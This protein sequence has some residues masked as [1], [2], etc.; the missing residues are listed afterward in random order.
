MAESPDRE[1][2]IVIGA[3]M[4]G[5][6]AAQVLTRHFRKVTLV[7]RDRLPDLPGYRKGVPQSRHTHLL[8]GLG[9]RSLERQ[10]PGLTAQLLA[11]G[12]VPL[13]LPGDAC[14]LTPAGWCE[15]FGTGM[16]FV[17]ASRDLIEWTV[18]QRVLSEPRLSLMT[19]TEATALVP[20]PD[21]SGIRGV[22]LRS[23]ASGEVFPLE[24]DLVL[25]ASGRGSRAPQWLTELGWPA[26]QE[27]SAPTA[28]GYASRF[29]ANPHR[30][31][32]DWKFLLL[33]TQ[34]PEHTRS[35]M[36]LPVDGDRWMVSLVGV[37]D[38]HPPTSDAGFLEFART[39]RSP[40]LYEAIR[41]AVP[42]TPVHSFRVPDSRRRRFDKMR[43]WPSGFALVGD[44][45]CSLNP[46]Y[47][48]GM[49]IAAATALA[50]DEELRRRSRKPLGRRIQR[51]AANV[52]ADAWLVA[53]S[54]DLRYLRPGQQVRQPIY[55]T[56][57]QGYF[58]RVLNASSVNPQ[59]NAALLQV[60]NLQ[61][62]PWSLLRPATALRAL[63][64]NGRAKE[65][66][67]EPE[68]P[69]QLTPPGGAGQP[70]TYSRLTV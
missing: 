6:L 11:A 22:R 60:L 3:G 10:L 54:E 42:L 35:G 33:Q 50:L 57:M 16:S 49:S 66:S 27:I 5:L 14:W 70:T 12:A 55:L 43:R 63:L 47:A 4:A 46:M 37:G 38:D 7:D 31:G 69:G 13:E 44:A 17:S 1:H 9:L 30:P 18:R 67:H 65:A 40:V 26:V 20:A 24:A 39:L 2:A 34:P 52:A 8:L 56:L 29:Y 62:S 15:R 64:V 28:V 51:R 19:A 36:L 45:V 53:S 32:Q 48:Q 59:V 21:G 58:D 68:G 25:D 23:R 41:D 61:A